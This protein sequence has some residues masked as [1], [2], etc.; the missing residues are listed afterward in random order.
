MLLARLAVAAVAAQEDTR[1]GCYSRPGLGLGILQNLD[2][3]PMSVEGRAAR[4]VV[5]VADS[6][7][8]AAVVGGH[9]G[10][11]SGFAA[12]SA[13]RAPAEVSYPLKTG[14]RVSALGLESRLRSAAP[15]G[16]GC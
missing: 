11:G 7:A 9:A 4:Y 15:A 8:Q 2:S 1:T 10:F 6:A 13:M 5:P 14:A 3:S 16:E 12:K